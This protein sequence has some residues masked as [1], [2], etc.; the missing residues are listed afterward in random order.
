[1]AVLNI[2]AFFLGH[3]VYYIVLAK[4]R[5]LKY[6]RYNDVKAVLEPIIGRFVTLQRVSS[7]VSNYSLNQREVIVHYEAWDISE[8][9]DTATVK[10]AVDT[11]TGN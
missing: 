5:Y 2:A 9:D 10:I 11:D 6:N 4:L 8:D 7:D 1:M 3:P